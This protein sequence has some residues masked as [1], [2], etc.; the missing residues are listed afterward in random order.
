M[1][2]H[3]YLVSVVWM[4]DSTKNVFLTNELEEAVIYAT[5]YMRW[6]NEINDAFQPDFAFIELFTN[7]KPDRVVYEVERGGKGRAID[8]KR[9]AP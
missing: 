4:H 7:H 1:P 3:M 5:D 6:A 8:T 2:Y 9:K